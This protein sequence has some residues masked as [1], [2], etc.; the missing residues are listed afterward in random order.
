[1]AGLYT[2]LLEVSDHELE[3]RHDAVFL[4]SCLAGC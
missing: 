4:Q 3:I 1:M 2:G